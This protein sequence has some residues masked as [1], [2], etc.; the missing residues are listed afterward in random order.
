MTN[1]EQKEK[2]EAEFDESQKLSGS[3]KMLST[4]STTTL[5]PTRTEPVREQQSS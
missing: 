4:L 3:I 2:F 1:Q 5:P